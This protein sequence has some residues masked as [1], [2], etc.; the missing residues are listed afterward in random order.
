MSSH[1]LFSIVGDANVRRNMTG[2]NIASRATMKS[3]QIIDC[4]Q[5]SGL[6]AT[7]K[8]KV[9]I[10]YFFVSTSLLPAFPC[11]IFLGSHF[12]TDWLSHLGHG[13]QVGSTTDHF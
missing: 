11:Q 12:R 1:R 2:L 8:L 4:V 9:P 10:K 13:N 5:I 3:A 6:D 7:R